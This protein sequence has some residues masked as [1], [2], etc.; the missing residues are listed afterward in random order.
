MLIYSF[1]SMAA[2]QKARE[3][4][5]A[6]GFNR[7]DLDINDS[8]HTDTE[9]SLDND[10]VVGGVLNPMGGVLST[11]D[12]TF[13]NGIVFAQTRNPLTDTPSSDEHMAY[14]TRLIVHEG[15]SDPDQ[16]DNIV[17]DYISLT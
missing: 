11:L 9:F 1:S 3:A 7:V 17:K 8:M 13:N 15:D 10:V 4:L 12:G 6:Q 16:V 5:K 14:K 2:A